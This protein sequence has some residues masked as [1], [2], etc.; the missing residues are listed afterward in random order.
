MRLGFQTQLLLDAI[1][2]TLGSAPCWTWWGEPQIASA[3]ARHQVQEAEIHR[4]DAELAVSEPSPIPLE[5][6]VDGVPEFL[7]VH[8][9]AIQELE[10]L[11][12]HLVASD[13]T[14][15][16]HINETAT[17]TTG[18]KRG[19]PDHLIANRS[20]QHTR[21]SGCRDGAFP[22]CCALFNTQPVEVII[23]HHVS[24]HSLPAT[25]MCAPCFPQ[26]RCG[27]SCSR[28][29][30]AVDQHEEN[31]PTSGGFWY[32][33]Q[34]RPH[35]LSDPSRFF[36]LPRNG[37]AAARVVHVNSIA[38]N[39]AELSNNSTKARSTMLWLCK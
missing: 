15:E 13:A 6:A 4:W 16:W 7:H 25:V 34:Q 29:Y 36:L 17:D 20:D 39:D 30:D 27:D 33:D 38:G 1:N 10:L 37:H 23:G 18:I 22:H 21:S 35:R 32:L 3:V 31:D 24:L 14:G 8:R 12:I 11:H 9:F 26:W 5:I 2:H 19:K 28:N